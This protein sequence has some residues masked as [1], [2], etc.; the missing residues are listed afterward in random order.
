MGLIPFHRSGLAFRKFIGVKFEDNYSRIYTLYVLNEDVTGW[1][2]VP[3]VVTRVV[4]HIRP[5]GIH[6][7]SIILFTSLYLK[8]GQ[9]SSTAHVLTPRLPETD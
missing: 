9:E 4:V 3:L 1:A 8:H 7:E 6:R 5:T 2:P